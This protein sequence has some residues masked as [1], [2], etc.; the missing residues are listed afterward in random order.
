[1]EECKIAKITINIH[2]DPFCSDGKKEFFY[3]PFCDK[4]T[5]CRNISD[6]SSRNLN[7]P[8]C[9]KNRV[10]NHEIRAHAQYPGVSNSFERPV[11]VIPIAQRFE[12]YEPYSYVSLNKPQFG[13]EIH[14]HI[15]KD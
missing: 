5:T 8:D 14:N 4:N 15:E 7:C 10:T 12:K 2:G 11:Q 9:G 13:N 3:C 6:L 1:M